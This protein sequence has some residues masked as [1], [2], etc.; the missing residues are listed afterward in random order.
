MGSPSYMRSVVDRNVF[1][2][3]IIVLHSNTTAGN[4]DYKTEILYLVLKITEFNNFGFCNSVNRVTR[5]PY[6]PNKRH[7]KLTIIYNSPAYNDNF[8]NRGTTTPYLKFNKDRKFPPS[9]KAT[10]CR[11][12]R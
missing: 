5:H 3:R 7:I 9:N 10:E 1:M 12:F 8:L 2:R 4:D 6:N 11:R